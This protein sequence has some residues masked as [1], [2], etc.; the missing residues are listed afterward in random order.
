MITQDII[1]KLKANEIP[2][3]ILK[4]KDWFTDEV[5]EFMKDV[6]TP[7][8]FYD[9]DGTW[10]AI[11]NTSN[12]FNASTYRLKQDYVLPNNK[13]IYSLLPIN[14][15][16]ITYF[17]NQGDDISENLN[18]IKTYNSFLGFWFGTKEE[19]DDF[20]THS[21]NIDYIPN[22]ASRIDYN[23]I[24]SKFIK[25]KIVKDIAKYVIVKGKD[26]E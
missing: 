21:K 20:I 10:K 23:F 11:N 7:I 3:G 15:D 25:G 8:E 2:Y 6:N 4:T 19:F 9:D 14:T 13:E 22:S 12:K 17:V 1:D 18:E 5:D 24:N 16:G 26:Y